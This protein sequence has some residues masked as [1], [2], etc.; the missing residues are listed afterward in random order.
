MRRLNWPSSPLGLRLLGV[1]LIT[2]GVLTL[3]PGLHFS[4]AGTLLALLAL[5]A[6]ILIL[7]GR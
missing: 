7:W 3:A 6:G 4:G 1:W 5:M 2:T